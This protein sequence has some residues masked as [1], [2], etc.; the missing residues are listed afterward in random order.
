[1]PN[2]PRRMTRQDVDLF[3]SEYYGRMRDD[4]ARNIDWQRDHPNERAANVLCSLAL[5]VYTEMMGT[6]SCARRYS[7]GA[8]YP[9][10]R[11]RSSADNHAHALR[12][13]R[14]WGGWA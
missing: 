10:A 1:M 6:G 4:L 2:A 11:R 12:V 13:R 9:S 3:F 5:V 8:S 14:S 7:A